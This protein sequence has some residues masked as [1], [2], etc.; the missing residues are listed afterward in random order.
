VDGIWSP[1]S[2]WSSCDVT[3]GS[4]SL[5][6]HRTCTNPAPQNGGL[7]CPGNG[8]ELK[9]CQLKLCPGKYILDAIKHKCFL[10]I[11]GN[12]AQHFKFIMIMHFS[13]EEL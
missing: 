12:F 8:T 6:R 13:T 7:D 4:G 1:W 3:C 11:F 5:L 9:T 2:S 10:N